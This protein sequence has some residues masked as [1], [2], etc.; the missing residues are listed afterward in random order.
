M[1]KSLVFTLFSPKMYLLTLQQC[2][3]VSRNRLLVILFKYIIQFFNSY[4]LELRG[5]TRNTRHKSV[6]KKVQRVAKSVYNDD[7]WV[8]V[9]CWNV[10]A[11]LET[12][13]S[14]I[15]TTNM[16]P[17][18]ITCGTQTYMDMMVKLHNTQ[19]VS[20]SVLSSLHH[21]YFHT[22]NIPHDTNGSS[23]CLALLYISSNLSGSFISSLPGLEL[24]VA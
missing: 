13:Y 3:H 14:N 20:V 23:F 5:K 6:W 11:R 12:G 9:V 18:P 7:V 4:S 2:C 10:V 8:T 24:L 19:S 15:T 16:S 22:S 21:D 17:A 1:S